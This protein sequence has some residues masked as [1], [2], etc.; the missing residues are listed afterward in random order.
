MLS[1]VLYDFNWG[2]T[3]I[4]KVFYLSGPIKFKEEK[5][6]IPCKRLGAIRLEIMK[7][8]AG[9]KLQQSF[10]LVLEGRNGW[11]HASWPR[12]YFICTCADD[13]HLLRR[14]ISISLSIRLEAVSSHLSDWGSWLQ[15]FNPKSGKYSWC[16]GASRNGFDLS[17]LD[18]QSQVLPCWRGLVFR[19]CLRWPRVACAWGES[20]DSSP[21]LLTRLLLF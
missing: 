5:S 14:P 9:R 10:E 15:F 2:L 8:V 13:A 18:E 11:S 1:L 4:I 12:P 21:V 17:D 19:P 7:V 20:S 3:T 6:W 16:D